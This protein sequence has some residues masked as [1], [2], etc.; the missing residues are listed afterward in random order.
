[1]IDQLTH[2]AAIIN[3]LKPVSIQARKSNSMG[4]LCKSNS[5]LV[6]KLVLQQHDPA[7]SHN[8]SHNLSR[9]SG[10]FANI[11]LNQKQG[12]FSQNVLPPFILNYI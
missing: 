9:L 5:V 2:S 8:G 7:G 1:M 11:R 12:G 4:Q 6:G 10:I 3:S